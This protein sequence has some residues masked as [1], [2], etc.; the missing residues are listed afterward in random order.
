MLI[1]ARD[2]A[3]GLD[4]ALNATLATAAALAVCDARAQA[5]VEAGAL[6]QVDALA[7]IAHG[8]LQAF[9][10]A[11]TAALGAD[12]LHYGNVLRSIQIARIALGIVCSAAILAMAIAFVVL[13]AWVARAVR[14][15]DARLAV[16]RARYALR[17]NRRLM[18]PL[19]APLVMLAWIMAGGY[20]AG[21]FIVSDLCVNPR[22]PIANAH[23]QNEHHCGTPHCTNLYPQADVGVHACCCP[24]SIANALPRTV[25]TIAAHY[26]E[27][28]GPTPELQRVMQGYLV[29]RTAEEVL[30]RFDCPVPAKAEPSHALRHSIPR[31]YGQTSC[32]L[33]Y[34]L[35]GGKH[36]SRLPH[37]FH[38]AVAF[39]CERKQALR[40]LDGLASGVGSLLS[41]TRCATINPVYVAFED[42]ICTDA[43]PYI[44]TAWVGALLVGIFLAATAMIFTLLLRRTLQ[45]ECAKLGLDVSAA[46]ALS[47]LSR[48]GGGSGS[49]DFKPAQQAP[50]HARWWHVKP[51][52]R[53]APPAAA[54]PADGQPA[55]MS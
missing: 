55:F 48:N 38:T 10:R 31:M 54:A 6:D 28:D 32:S 46:A 30:T 24:Q 4:A 26:M 39:R 8:A 18:L 37:G 53:T 42:A 3:V 1:D 5:A 51:F 17:L 11:D 15:G 13:S 21:G 25:G 36:P 45:E 33:H 27:C 23:A 7:A 14:G 16:K 43:T 52:W 9:V 19:A 35:C 2:T 22:Q 12:V 44:L 34:L 50:A 47:P 40:G 20:A 29:L 49:E 41:D